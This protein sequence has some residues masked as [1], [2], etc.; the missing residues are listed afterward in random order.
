MPSYGMVP[1]VYAEVQ[2]TCRAA[3]GAH[4]AAAAEDWGRSM[5]H[6]EL[7]DAA[8]HTAPHTQPADVEQP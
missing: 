6:A 3:L 2:S 8:V 5:T 7:V 4:A 1:E